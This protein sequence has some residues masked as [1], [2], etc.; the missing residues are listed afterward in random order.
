MTAVIRGPKPTCVPVTA[1]DTPTLN[2]SH[3][4]PNVHLSPGP[5]RRSCFL[6]GRGACLCVCFCCVWPSYP[7][8]LNPGYPVGAH[9]VLTFFL[10]RSVLPDVLRLVFLKCWIVRIR[11][12]L[13][14]GW[15]GQGGGSMKTQIP[16][17]HPCDSI[18]GQGGGGG[19]SRRM[20]RGLN[21][22]IL[23]QPLKFPEESPAPEV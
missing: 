12:P 3:R 6:W 21:V 5:L 16:G 22:S 17:L 9:L 1:W 8:G 23:S 11:I 10:S 20:C 14:W 2:P 19:S 13:S 18:P 15:G 4:L 7:L